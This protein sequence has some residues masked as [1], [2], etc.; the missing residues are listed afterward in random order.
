MNKVPVYL[1]HGYRDAL[2]TSTPVFKGCS[3]KETSSKTGQSLFS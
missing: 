2:A 3:L 1:H